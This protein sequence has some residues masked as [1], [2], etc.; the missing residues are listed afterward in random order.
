MMNDLLLLD[1]VFI[2]I[3]LKNE[4]LIRNN[5]LKSAFIDI[6]ELSHAFYTID[7]KF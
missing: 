3:R 1:L 4:Y 6:T 5:I 7:K 2:W